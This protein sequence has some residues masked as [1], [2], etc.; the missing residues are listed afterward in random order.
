MRNEARE[1]KTSDGYPLKGTLLLP[2]GEIKAVV[3]VNPATGTK[4][5]YYQPYANFLA[6]QGYA[7]FIWNYRG[8]CESKVGTLKNSSFR[9]RTPVL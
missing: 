1:I 3:Q 5:S 9:F 2:T 4:T 6:E 8:F 7:V